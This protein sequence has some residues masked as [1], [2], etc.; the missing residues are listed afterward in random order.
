M[1]THPYLGGFHSLLSRAYHIRGP[2]SMDNILSQSVSTLPQRH[3]LLVRYHDQSSRQQPNDQTCTVHT[4]QGCQLHNTRHTPNNITTTVTTATTTT[5]DI[6]RSNIVQ[7]LLTNI[8]NTVGADEIL[9]FNVGSPNQRQSNSEYIT[10]M[11]YH[12]Y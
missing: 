7:Q 11:S 10:M 3:P 4:N 8:S 6:Q 12:N 5:T 1:D 2:S 9:S